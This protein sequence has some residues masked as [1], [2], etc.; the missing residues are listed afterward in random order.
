[1]T[2]VMEDCQYNK[3]Y[4]DE[5]PACDNGAQFVVISTCCG[6][7]LNGCLD[8]VVEFMNQVGGINGELDHPACGA[9]GTAGFRIE[10]IT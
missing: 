3:G 8:H 7:S 1:M 4:L 2:A 10:A 9:S 5:F 6:E